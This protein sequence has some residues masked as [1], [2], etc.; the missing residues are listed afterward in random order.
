MPLSLDSLKPDRQ[1]VSLAYR[2]ASPLAFVYG[3]HM[4]KTRPPHDWYFKDWCDQCG[5][6][7]ADLVADLG[8]NISKA[9]LFWNGKQ[10]YHREDVNE[11]AAYLGVMPFELLLHPEEAN[12]IKRLRVSARQIAAADLAYSKAAELPDD[13]AAIAKPR[14]A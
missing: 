2:K 13:I 8:W 6:K 10:R 5:K 3:L 4:V 11:I 14:R 7:Q 1:Q 12:A 9:S